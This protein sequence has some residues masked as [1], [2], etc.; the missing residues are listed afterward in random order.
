MG[1]DR[2]LEVLATSPGGLTDAEVEVRRVVFGSNEIKEQSRLSRAQIIFGQFTSPLILILVATGLITTFLREWVETGVIFAAVLINAFLGFWQENKAETVLE[3]LKSY[4]RTR[5]RV[6]RGGLEREVDAGEL[7]PGDLIRVTQGDRVPADARC[8]FVNDLEIDESVLTGE[9]MP[10]KKT[11]DVCP[12]HTPLADRTSMLYGGTLAVQGFAD[13]VVTA[14]GSETEFGKIASLVALAKKEA[15]P[16]QRATQRFATYAGGALGILTVVLFGFG[17]YFGKSVYD[18][19]LVAVAVGVSAVPEGLPIA[20]TVILAVGVQRLAGQGGIVRKLLA[21]ETLGSTSLILTDKTGTLT[22]AR[23]ELVAVL[24]Y[25][26]D[27]EEEKT[28]LLSDALLN[29]DIVIENP[30]DAP[31]TWRTFGPALEVALT[32]Y[33]ARQ[34]VLLPKILETTKVLDRVPFNSKDK[35]SATAFRAGSHVRLVLLGAPD[36]LLRFTHAS[37]E[38]R[39]RVLEQINERASTGERLL[40]VISQEAVSHDKE[41]LHHRAFHNFTFRGLLAFRD[42]LRPHAREAIHEIAM[43]GVKTIIVTGDHQGTAMAVARELGILKEGETAI[44]GDELKHISAEDLA[45][46][47]QTIRVYARVTPEQKVFIAKTYKA[48]GEIVAMT[49]DGVNDA[50]ALQVADIGVAVGSGSDVAKGVA[51][52]VILNDNFETIVSAIKEGRR[53]LENIRKVIIYLLSNAFDELLL[54]GGSLAVGVALPLNALQILFVNIF[55]DSFPAIALAFEEGI[56]DIGKKPKQ[57]DKNLFD[58]QMRFFIL[59]IGVSTSVFLLALYLFL[60]RAGFA[61]ALVRTFIFASFASYTLLLS[62]S[63]RSLEKS[64]VRYNPLSNIHLTAG[65]GIG[66]GLTFAAVYIPWLQRALDTV[67]LPLSWLLGVLC[68]GIANVGIIEFGKWLFRKKLL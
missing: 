26:A 8:I 17:I 44:T 21:A 36:I 53:I 59:V 66:L 46:R 51:D 4:V 13:A 25:G 62:F 38:E 55:S 48:Q 52:L 47:A 20:L 22:Q 42:P 64:I 57:L 45:A 41:M 27:T 10:E 6:R 29:T 28:K 9:S 19:F 65:V 1:A 23:M 37:P 16:L 61:Q 11:V 35:F 60:L 7:M 32:K 68:F 12:Q 31:A 3:L 39:E 67:P 24:P 40:G 58:K 50:P 49:G 18:M 15:T 2:A 54:I 5:A 56:D 63:L 34:G 33:A 43:A 14:T 30:H